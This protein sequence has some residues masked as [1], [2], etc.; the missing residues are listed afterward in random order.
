M[1]LLVIWKP[2]QELAVR[3]WTR[4]CSLTNK[5]SALRV[6]NSPLRSPETANEK[7]V[8]VMIGYVGDKWPEG[9]F[10]TSGALSIC[11]SPACC[12]LPKLALESLSFNQIVIDV[13]WHL[14]A[15]ACFIDIR[16]RAKPAAG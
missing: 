4:L 12:S 16:F 2:V 11:T 7:N 10:S 1:I 5:W 13:N 8:V 6:S 15:S 9:T 3:T 14:E